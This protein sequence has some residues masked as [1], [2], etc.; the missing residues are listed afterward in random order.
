MQK[1]V[2]FLLTSLVIGLPM[3]GVYAAAQAQMESKFIKDR[4]ETETELFKRAEAG[5]AAAAGGSWVFTKK[6]TKGGP[7]AIAAGQGS[8]GSLV[9]PQDTQIFRSTALSNHHYAGEIFDACSNGASL[10]RFYPD[11][12]S[13][14]GT[15]VWSANS[16]FIAD[17][18]T[19]IP[20]IRIWDVHAEKVATLTCQSNP[21]DVF[22]DPQGRY[23][24]VLGSGRKID[25]FDATTKTKVHAGEAY[26]RFAKDT[27]VVWNPSGTY[28]SIALSEA[29]DAGGECGGKIG[30][31]RVHDGVLIP[32]KQYKQN[33]ER[34]AW[35]NDTTFLFIDEQG[36]C[37]D[38]VDG[39]VDGTV[40][41]ILGLGK[42]G[43][44]L[45]VQLFC[46]K[47]E[48]HLAVVTYQDTKQKQN[49]I[50]VFDL[51]NRSTILFGLSTRVSEYKDIRSGVKYETQPGE[52][53]LG[54]QD[55]R[56]L[57]RDRRTGVVQTYD[58]TWRR[59]NPIPCC[60][61]EP[62]QEFNA[63]ERVNYTISMSPSGD[64][65]VCRHSSGKIKI[66][67][68]W[69]GREVLSRAANASQ[70]PQ[71]S[72]DGKKL[73]IQ[74]LND[75][76]VVE[77]QGAQPQGAQRALAP[78]VIHAHN[79]MA[80]PAENPAPMHRRKFW[81][82]LR[83]PKVYGSLL[84]ILA[85]SVGGSSYYTWWKKHRLPLVV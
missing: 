41:D 42:Q 84:F 30:L 77:R 65:F 12:N 27:Q 47:P 69:S 36:L 11:V 20:A 31:Y 72:V 24:T 29:G 64:E 45:V 63:R 58:L 48:S 57:V 50:F 49:S 75:V 52:C 38:N 37:L 22:W 61:V 66:F 33:V 44:H 74:C 17:Y 32:L 21:L 54:A 23:L 80:A 79:L 3:P 62:F 28:V 2:R 43:E 10:K 68:C 35:L 71:W 40:E 56:L 73:L 18:T 8:R 60:T 15:V 13:D 78:R 19:G 9:N 82:F 55:S 67:D 1:I 25:I 51:E 5:E 6:H 85:L 16:Q 26:D 59:Q 81:S 83:K 46:S 76:F 4:Q 53:Y 14:I 39:G 34:V 7:G 70:W